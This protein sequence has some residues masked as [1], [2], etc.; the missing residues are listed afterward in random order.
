MSAGEEFTKK[1]QNEVNK[2]DVFIFLISPDS[3]EKG[4]YSLTELEYAKTK[5][6]NAHN[7]IL[8][9]VV[10]QTSDDLI[11]DYLKSV[12]ISS[13]KGNIAVSVSEDVSKFEERLNQ[14]KN[15]RFTPL[16]ILNSIVKRGYQIVW[17]LIL[18]V[19]LGKLGI[20]LT[21]PS[22]PI[23]QNQPETITPTTPKV[24]TSNCQKIDAAFMSAIK[25]ARKTAK[26]NAEKKLEKLTNSFMKRVDENFLD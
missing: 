4:R 14:Q 16:S 15:I 7:R 5:W 25:E 23:T 8:P 13:P 6:P 10:K 2:S 1:I 17:I 24:S 11:P 21:S 26:E 18:L 3:V 20:I 9:V 19:V 12:T 22:E